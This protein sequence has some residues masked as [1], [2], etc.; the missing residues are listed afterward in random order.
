M[1]GEPRDGGPMR[2]SAGLGFRFH[3]LLALG[4]LVPAAF[5]AIIG[6]F[7]LRELDDRMLHGRE[8]AAA[9]VS[10]RLQA[11]LGVDLEV[12]QRLAAV[13]RG[14][15]GAATP[16]VDATP[17]R[18]GR[19]Q[20]HYLGGVFLL[21]RDGRVLLEEPQ[22][23]R[24]VAPSPDLPELRA[25]LDTAKPAITGLV[26]ADGTSRAWALV[27]VTD[28]EGRAV[29]A[30]GGVL[31]HA[32]SHEPRPLSML[33]LSPGGTAVVVDS[34][35]GILAGTSG[36]ADLSD[37][38]IQRIAEAARGRQ[39]T[40]GAWAE[41]DSASA[42][43]VVAAAPVLVAPWAVAVIE[44]AEQVLATTTLMPGSLPLLALALILIAGAF[45][46]GTARSVTR[47]V[48]TLTAAAER[49]AGGVFEPAIPD[50]GDDEVGRLG[51]SL[52]DMRVALSELVA[53]RARHAE[54]L[55][56]RVAERTRE[57]EI[58]NAQLRERDEARAKLL[59]MVIT[60]QE[61]ERKR[62]AR[63][64]HDDTT[65]KLAVLVM[66]VERAAQ[67]LRQEGRPVPLEE[68]KQL[69]VSA[70]DEVHRLIRDLRPSVLDDLG[71]YSAVRWYAENTL[72]PRGI[73]LRCELGELEPTLPAAWD[74]ALFRMCQEAVNNVARHAQAETVLIQLGVEDGELRIEIEDDGRG[75]E[76]DAPRPEGDR[77]HWGLIGIRERAEL[78]GGTA[79]IESSPGH[80]TRVEIRVR[81]PQ[82]AVAAGR[83]QA[84][85][86]G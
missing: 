29:G 81:L 5:V 20:F 70:L 68:V 12:L 47:P 37:A 63:E 38:C 3:V 60:A 21:D 42:S 67:A 39:T 4:M 32:L 23:E 66:G 8:E 18:Q 54:E 86:E 26:R 57:L 56:R 69:A 64:L 25:V 1:S 14:P 43:V 6:L 73:A 40:A 33:S 77:L 46:W 27:A 41:C 28:W 52:E 15:L 48:A 17:F 36:A 84:A 11:E 58:A 50:L 10:A 44:P 65:Q 16:V 13:S 30:V 7:R 75:F 53:E 45:A 62:I 59:R 85:G 35:G 80:G 19:A 31:D 49:I 61:D 72:S 2:L 78:L 71:L 76:P 24:S 51:N 9:L 22:R 74:I 55:E 79:R 83:R 82:D 34:H